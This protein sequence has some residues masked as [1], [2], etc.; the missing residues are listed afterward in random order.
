M[1]LFATLNL[2]NF[3]LLTAIATVT[4]S[5]LMGSIP[6]LPFI[7]PLHPVRYPSF[8]LLSFVMPTL[9]VH[10]FLTYKRLPKSHVILRFCANITAVASVVMLT[11]AST[12]P[13]IFGLCFAYILLGVAYSALQATAPFLVV[14]S[15]DSTSE[16]RRRYYTGLHLAFLNGCTALGAVV[17]PPFFA[18]LAVT[19]VK[20][21]PTVVPPFVLAATT[22]G[23]LAITVFYSTRK[24]LLSAALSASERTPL[25]GVTSS[26]S[27]SRTEE[28]APVKR[29]L[30]HPWAWLVFLSVLATNGIMSFLRPLL[31]PTILQSSHGVMKAS[32]V[33]G[34]VT[35]TSLLAEVV[36]PSF[37]APQIGTRTTLVVGIVLV[38]IGSHFLG[39]MPISVVF[40]II[41]FGA[42]TV[43][44]IALSD[45]ALTI[46]DTIDYS[47][48]ASM[49]ALSLITVS[50][51]VAYL[52]ASALPDLH[53]SNFVSHAAAIVGPIMTAVA[54][55]V[56]LPYV[57]GLVVSR[58]VPVIMLFRSPG[59][60]EPSVQET[61]SLPLPTTLTPDRPLISL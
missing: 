56:I 52:G 19:S 6:I 34:L 7:F 20:T 58:I 9:P 38:T 14:D 18:L 13:Y 46:N 28:R 12:Q 54:V 57:L 15:L 49:L 25:L 40:C 47:T 5:T 16:S 31:A 43:P 33:F 39:R 44:V 35:A 26:Q 29:I 4:F 45:L 24:S 27:I 22:H 21:N 55:I 32:F 2:P 42:A 50:D 17:T 59:P 8:C 10:I 51:I 48:P 11:L 61:Q 37:I 1:T 36:I 41:A 60:A 23:L 53:A 3:G 30:R